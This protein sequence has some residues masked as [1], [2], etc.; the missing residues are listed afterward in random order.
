MS[1]C[2]AVCKGRRDRSFLLFMRIGSRLR[3]K[4]VAQSHRDSEGSNGRQYTVCV[5]V[6]LYPPRRNA[7][8]VAYE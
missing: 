5:C 8:L 1:Y 7:G 6:V 2:M 4:V 3:D